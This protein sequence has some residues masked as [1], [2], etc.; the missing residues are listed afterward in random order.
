MVRYISKPEPPGALGANI[1]N[2]RVPT[3][4]K[5]LDEFEETRDPIACMLVGKRL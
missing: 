5:R 2:R 3:L 4:V 1:P